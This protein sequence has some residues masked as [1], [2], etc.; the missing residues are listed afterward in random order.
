A[1][2]FVEEVQEKYKRDQFAKLHRSM[3]NHLATEPKDKPIA[4]TC[5]EGHGRRI[6]SPYSHHAQ[7]ALAERVRAL[8]KTLIFMRLADKCFYLADTLEVIHEERIHGAG[9]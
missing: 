4:K 2:R 1:N 9:R 7:S 3:H 6:G 5:G 8:G